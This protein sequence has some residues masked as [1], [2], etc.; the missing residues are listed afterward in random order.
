MHVTDSLVDIAGNTSFLD[1]AASRD[2]GEEEYEVWFIAV[3]ITVDIHKGANYRRPFS[4]QIDF[5]S[6][7]VYES[8]RFCFPI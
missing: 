2:G 4:N 5:K 7:F 1:N 3:W 8:N 6:I